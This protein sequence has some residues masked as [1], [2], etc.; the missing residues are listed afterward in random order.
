MLEITPAAIG[1]LIPSPSEGDFRSFELI[2]LHLYG[3]VVH[4]SPTREEA[5][6]ILS[7]KKLPLFNIVRVYN[8]D[9]AAVHVLTISAADT[10]SCLYLI[11]PPL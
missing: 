2:V 9:A 1:S 11:V 8:A 6:S 5:A 10:T 7:E 4:H 3:S